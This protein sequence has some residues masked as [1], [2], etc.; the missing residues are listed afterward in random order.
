MSV[1]GSV[2]PKSL[3]PVFL[4]LQ[5]NLL[6]ANVVVITIPP[7]IMFMFFQWQLVSGLTAGAKCL[8]KTDSKRNFQRLII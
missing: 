7:L 4:V 6:F 1:A 3:L 5:A 2:G 8:N